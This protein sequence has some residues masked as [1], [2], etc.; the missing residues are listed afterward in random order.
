MESTIPF[1]DPCYGYW[2]KIEA[3]QG[4]TVASVFLSVE[5]SSSAAPYFTVRAVQNGTADVGVKA[6]DIGLWAFSWFKYD[7]GIGDYVEISGAHDNFYEIT[8]I[9]GAACSKQGYYHVQASDPCLERDAAFSDAIVTIQ[10]C[11]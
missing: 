3:H 11:P 4:G 5:S 8:E 6:A 9:T 1:T 7:D 10:G 2:Y